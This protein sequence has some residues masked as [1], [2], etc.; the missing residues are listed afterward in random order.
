MADIFELFRQISKKEESSPTPIT[1][2]IVGLG[3]PGDKYIHTRHN[4][5]FLA[6]DYF[7]Q[8]LG[9]RIERAKFHALC[10]EAQVGK[11]RVLLMKPQTMMNASGQAVREA[12]DF[13]KLSP[14]NIIVISD[15][16]T[17]APGKIRIRRK[18]SAGGHNGLKDIIYQLS[19]DAFPR[20]RL[21]VGEKPHPDYD[22]AAWVLSD[23]PKEEQHLLFGA[24][25]CVSD[26][27][28]RLIDGDFDGA[29]QLCN[30][31]VPT[32]KEKE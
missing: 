9:V 1:H 30:S 16:I 24:F 11:H 13:Y 8:T 31:Y 4:A 12:A 2:L 14:E 17:Q 28:R 22:L 26:G 3:N 32:P 27:L 29:Q 10:A 7:S 20:I 21:G 5:G 23:F 18:G 6:L 19:S 15:D 25:G